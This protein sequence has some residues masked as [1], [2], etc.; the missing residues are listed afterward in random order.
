IAS[1]AM[2][3]A[4][5]IP[6]PVAD[7]QLRV[8][9]APSVAGLATTGGT[10]ITSLSSPGTE[11]L[12][13][14]IPSRKDVVCGNPQTNTTTLRIIHGSQARSVSEAR[15]L[16]RASFAGALADARA[17]DACRQ[18]RLGCQSFTNDPS[19]AIDKIAATTS[20]THGP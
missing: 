8:K 4:K 5:K 7:N 13:A 18:I 19:A 3:D 10:R 12:G 14:E 1:P 2:I 6:L 11:I 17:S 15:P 9:T 20:T 16:G